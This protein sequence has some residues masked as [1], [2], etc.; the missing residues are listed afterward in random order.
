MTADILFAICITAALGIA[1]GQLGKISYYIAGV[2]ITL[3]VVLL[4][5]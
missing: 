2:F 3:A 4:F 1:I 5:I